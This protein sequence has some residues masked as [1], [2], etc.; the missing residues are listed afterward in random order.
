MPNY[1]FTIPDD[2]YQEMKKHPEIKWS[3]I[4]RR[5][6][7]IYLDKL[8]N[9]DEI[10]A[11]ELLSRLG[12]DLSKITDGDAIIHAKKSR[13]AAKERIFYDDGGN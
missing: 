8:N 3:E 2:L 10:K 1:T 5:A 13:D 4:F 6:L 7:K 11:T 9:V 12:I